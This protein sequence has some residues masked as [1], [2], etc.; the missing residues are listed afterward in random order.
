MHLF[1]QVMLLFFRPEQNLHIHQWYIGHVPQPWGYKLLT[2]DAGHH[3]HD[4]R[5]ELIPADHVA[6]KSYLCFDIPDQFLCMGVHLVPPVR[7]LAT[8]SVF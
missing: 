7:A 1:N 8:T 6:G 3:R 4:A 5:V 2:W